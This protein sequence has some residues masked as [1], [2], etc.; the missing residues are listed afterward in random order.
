ME[1]RT[2]TGASLVVRTGMM[3]FAENNREHRSLPAWLAMAALLALLGIAIAVS[4]P[5]STQGLVQIPS[6]T[7]L[8][9]WQVT[10]T[11]PNGNAIADVPT[12][13][14][15]PTDLTGLAAGS[16]VSL[17][18]T[19]WAPANAVLYLSTYYAPFEVLAD[20]QPVA[21]YGQAGSYPS[22][23][24]SPAPASICCLVTHEAGPV[25]L[26]LRFEVPS[27][28]WGLRLISPRI[29]TPDAMR[30]WLFT[31]MGVQTFL[32]ITILSLGIVLV[33]MSFFLK[34]FRRES[35]LVRWL[36]LLNFF[37]GIWT[38]GE[39]NLSCILITRPVLLHFLTY[40]G[41]FSMPIALSH[42]MM[43][44]DEERSTRRMGSI[45]CL[46]NEAFV[47]IAVAGQLLG[48]IQFSD[49][50]FV[51][52]VVVI[53]TYI[54]LSVH[55][56]A[57]ALRA[58]RRNRLQLWYLAVLYVFDV[59]LLMELLN[60]YVWRIVPEMTFSLAGTIIF[61][62]L[63]CATAFSVTRNAVRSRRQNLELQ[64]NARIMQLRDAAQ[65][66]Q[67]HLVQELSR[68]IRRQRHDM[69][70][71]IAVVR[72]YNDAG[73]HDGLES[74]ISSLQERIPQGGL[75]DF[76]PNF[77]INAI[78]SY[79]Y[80]RASER[81]VTDIDVKLDIP[82]DLDLGDEDDLSSIVGNLLENAVAAAAE[83]EKDG[84]RGW[85]RIRGVCQGR[86]LALVAENSYRA[87]DQTGPNS[88]RSTK[89]DGTGIGLRSI[90][91]CARRH[92]GL[93]CFSAEDGRFVAKVTFEL[94][95][96]KEEA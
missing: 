70:H 80:D 85:V 43:L 25:E 66:E 65:R 92:Q 89:A 39:S 94:L 64:H 56:T 9:S 35:L 54:A 22:F 7:E 51:Y 62:C 72:A 2:S 29:G 19:V 13:I 10:A 74:F 34:D 18:S 26:T 73:D 4:A 82:S 96:S 50:L 3:R 6:V 88:F 93:A 16:T 12:T 11:D 31:S 63:S 15:S 55:M 46:V 41:L 69:K 67:Y 79:Y 5:W 61:T 17:T 87:V 52:Y 47:L 27:H 45:S 32:G 24:A 38:L 14:D 91:A 71:Q 48:L 23:L 49:S 84:G 86:K 59:F 95:A 20:G 58:R 37:D 36:G 40:I 78:A 42:L 75:A 57:Q 81:G 76:C 30:R 1:S 8:T 68:E 53:P 90:E 28:Y 77:A 83:V 33:I 60:Y 21:S 44:L